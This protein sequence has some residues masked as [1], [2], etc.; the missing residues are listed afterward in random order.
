[1]KNWSQEKPDELKSQ[2]RKKTRGV[3]SKF[4]NKEMDFSISCKFIVYHIFQ[5]KKYSIFKSGMRGNILS[6]DFFLGLFAA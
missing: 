6:V 3:F 2:K 4:V 5:P 1:M